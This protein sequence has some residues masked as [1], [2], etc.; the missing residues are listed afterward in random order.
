MFLKKLPAISF[1]CIAAFYIVLLFIGPRVPDSLQKEYCVRNFELGSVF[2]HSMNC[3]SADYMHN[4]SD[5]IR[6]LDKD[7]IRQPR[8]GLILLSHLI[9]YPINFIVKKSFGLDGYPQKTIRFKNDGSKYIINELFHPKIVYSSYLLINLFILFFSIYFFF[10]IFNL[11]IFSYKSYQNWIYWFALLII[12]NNTVNQ[13]LYS[14]ST[15]LFNIFLSIITI[16]YSTEI[17]KKKKLKL[18]PLFLFL[19]ICMLFYLAFFIPFIIFLFLVTMS[20]KN[21]KISLKLIKLFYLSLIFVIPYSIWVFL[22]ISINGSFYVSNFENYKMVVW[23]WDYFNANNLALTLYKLLYDYLDF[24]KIFLISHWFIF[25]LILPFFIFF[26]KLNFDLD[27]NIYKSVTILTII[28]PL[29][30]VLLAHRPLDIISV[31][32]IPF[33]VIITEFLRNNIQKCFK[34]RATKIYYTLFSV[35]FFFWYVSKFGPYS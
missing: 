7:S 13:F 29:F 21:G 15:K 17:Y 27:N 2:G 6:L 8:P 14:P 10:R 4:S 35:P 3:D 9:S 26:K 1:W 33:S 18:E 32:I 20:D 22:I 12:I 24:F 19:G 23:I 34:Q 16:F 28:Y 30:Y 5:P 31:L 25:I 11:N